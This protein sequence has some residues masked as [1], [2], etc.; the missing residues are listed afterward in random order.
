MSQEEKFIIDLYESH[1]DDHWYIQGRYDLLMDVI[2]RCGVSNDSVCL[3]AGSGTGA[4]SKRIRSEIGCRVCE[5]DSSPYSE[6]YAS[7]NEWF[8]S[9]DITNLDVPD[10]YY[11]FV[12]CIDV[13]EHIENPDAAVKEF[14]RVLKPGGTLIVSLPAH[15]CLWGQH[16]DLSGHVK[17]FTQKELNELLDVSG[18]KLVFS[19]YQQLVFF[20]PMFLFR[21]IK[22]L[23]GSNKSDFSITP[24]LFNTMFRFIV[25]ME[26]YLIG[27]VFIPFG[28]NVLG[29][30]KKV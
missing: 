18:L 20:L 4:L 23:T 13:L 24:N 19:S 26:K 12:L 1:G 10:D 3:D 7:E 30:S 16:D 2:Q 22:K 27:R 6:E 9:G 25:R 28:I 5:V 11:D 14:K 29:V 15:M 21:K 8:F 17:R